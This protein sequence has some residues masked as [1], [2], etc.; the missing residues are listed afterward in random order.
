M[1]GGRYG[2]T[3]A[4]RAMLTVA[5]TVAA[6]AA[7][8]TF[9]EPARAQWRLVPEVRLTGGDESDLVVD[10]GVNR[11]VVPGGPFAEITPMLTLRWSGSASRADI[12]TYATVQR[13]LNDDNRLLYAQ[14]VWGDLYKDLGKNFRGRI[15]AVAEYFDD[16]E[17]ETVERFGGGGDVG[18]ALLGPRWNA[19]LFAGARGRQYPNLTT[20]DTGSSS[21]TYAEATWSGGTTLR[22]S[23]AE[24]F[25]LRGDAVFLT[26]DA[27][28]PYYDSRSWTVSANIDA[29]LVSSAFLTLFGAYQERDFTDR[30]LAEDDDTYWQV[31]TGLRYVV[32]GAWTASVRYGYSM[33]TWPDGSDENS[34]RLAVAIHYAW[35]NAHV[36]PVPRVD[37][38]ALTRESGGS[39]QQPDA[40]GNVRLRLHAPTAGSVSVAGDFNAWNAEDTRL[41]PAGDGWWEID[42]RL[43]P[44][45]YEYIY[46]IDGRWTTPPEAKITT[47]DGFGGRNGVL[48]I[49]PTDA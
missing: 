30:P 40:A 20:A 47:E 9:S 23:P 43:A 1:R 3:V 28:D 13:F 25:A 31:G 8:L 29:R 14:T 27:R 6:A 24:R 19:E 38:D 21:T 36:P 45:N 4:V 15:S 26:T 41:R 17:R 22:M 18:I 2:H 44:G 39:V 48:E 11:I 46:V 12:G 35:G 16:S 5:L 34:H 49:L 33:Y 32:A 10:P 42:L 7:V 37:I